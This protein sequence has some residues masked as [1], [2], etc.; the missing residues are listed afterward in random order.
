ME[1]RKELRSALWS[2]GEDKQVAL[3]QLIPGGQQFPDILKTLGLPLPSSTGRWVSESQSKDL[4][5]NDFDGQ[6]WNL[7]GYSIEVYN[8]KPG[9]QGIDCL[10][11][12]V[13]LKN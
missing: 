12:C 5:T 6:C 10:G 8:L 11:L 9:S 13:F 1:T 4:Q 3:G 7:Q 2:L